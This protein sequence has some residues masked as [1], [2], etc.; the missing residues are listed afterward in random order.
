MSK[1][2]PHIALLG[3]AIECNRFAPVATRQHFSHFAGAALIAEARTAAPRLHPEMPGFV[4]AMDAAGPWTPVPIVL[5]AA[6]PNGPVEHGFFAAILEEIR[7]GLSAAG[8]LDGVY[9]CEHGAALTTED[10]DPDGTLFAAVRAI[11][12]PG[13]PVVATLDLH[14]NISARMVEALDVFVGYRTNPHLDMRERG[15]EAAA[16]L[17]QMLGGVKP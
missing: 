17:R 8:R 10:D 14:A 4:A 16:A 15:A 7:A 13:V 6:A 1:D 5:A 3:F 9:I 12:G 11:V 2:T